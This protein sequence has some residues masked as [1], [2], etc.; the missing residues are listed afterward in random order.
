MIEL[1]LVVDWMWENEGE[2]K[3]CKDFLMGIGAEQDLY[4][5]GIQWYR[6]KSFL[7]L[8]ILLY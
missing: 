2:G 7:L 4:S 5:G 1:N 3:V 8:F 6:E